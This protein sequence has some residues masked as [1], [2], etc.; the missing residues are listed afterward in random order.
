MVENNLT[1]LKDKFLT[2][3]SFI[4]VR[5][6]LTRLLSAYR[7]RIV[8]Q[9]CSFQATEYIEAMYE[10]NPMSQ[11]YV[12]CLLGNEHTFTHAMNECS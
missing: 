12:L 11:P 4:V 2:Y 9:P 7:D 5:H 1:V 6:P 10:A 8:Q 3:Y